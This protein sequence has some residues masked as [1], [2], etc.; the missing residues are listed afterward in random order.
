MILVEMFDRKSIQKTNTFLVIPMP[1]NHQADQ[2]ECFLHSHRVTR[3][4]LQL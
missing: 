4:R 1:R 2:L 3:T